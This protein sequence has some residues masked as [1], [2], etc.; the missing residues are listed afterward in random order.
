MNNLQGE[1]VAPKD[2]AEA[3]A[4]YLQDKHW[5]NETNVPVQQMDRIQDLRH[6]FDHGPFAMIEFN[7]CFGFH[8]NE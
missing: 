4:T 2:R 7:A 1:Y 8:Q 6:L 5:T 3:I